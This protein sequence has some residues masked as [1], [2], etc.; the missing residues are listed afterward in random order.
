[1]LAATV[2][3]IVPTKE[4]APARFIVLSEVVVTAHANTV[5]ALASAQNTDPLLALSSAVEPINELLITPAE[6][7]AIVLPSLSIMPVEELSTVLAIAPAEEA[8]AALTMAHVDAAAPSL[9]V[10]HM[11]TAAT[12]LVI[13]IC[14]PG[15]CSRCHVQANE[16][17][18]TVGF[19]ALW[20]FYSSEGCSL[21]IHGAQFPNPASGQLLFSTNMTVSEHF[22]FFKELVRL[23]SNPTAVSFKELVRLVSNPGSG[24]GFRNLVVLVL[25]NQYV[26]KCFNSSCNIGTIHSYRSGQWFAGPYSG[27]SAEFSLADSDFDNLKLLPSQLFNA[28]NLAVPAAVT[29]H[30]EFF[31]S[32]LIF[33]PGLH[34]IVSVDFCS[35]MRQAAS[36]VDAQDHL[37]SVL[38]CMIRV[39]PTA[40]CSFV[41]SLL[42]PYWI[43]DKELCLTRHCELHDVD[44]PSSSVQEIKLFL[45][46]CAHCDMKL[47]QMD[48]TTAFISVA[49][50]HGELICCNPHCG[51]DI[52]L[53]SNGVPSVWK[54]QA[55]LESSCLAAMCW[56]ESSSIP[57]QSCG[58]VPIRSGSVFWMYHPLLEKMLLC[59]HV[60]DFPLAAFSLCLAQRFHAHY[61]LHCDCK[62][63]ITRTC[64]GIDIILDLDA[65]KMYLSQATLINCLLE[66]EL[67]GIMCHEHLTSTD[68][69]YN[70]GKDLHKWEQFCPCSTSFGYKMPKLLL[71]DS[72]DSQIP[73]PVLVHWK[74]VAVG[75]LMCTLNS[76]PDLTHPVHQVGCFVHNPGPAHAKAIDHFL[77]YLAGS[78]NFCL[79]VGN[80]TLFDLRFLAC[81]TVKADTSHKNLELDF[82]GITGIGIFV[83]C[84]LL[85]ARSLVQDQVAVSSAENEYYSSSS[86]VK[87]LDEPAIAMSQGPAHCSCTKHIDFTKALVRDYAQRERAGMEHCPTDEQFAD[88]WIKQLGLGSFVAYTG[89]FMSLV[90]FLRI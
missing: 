72:P 79:F 52:G 37:G 56:T 54:L 82:C 84:T 43:A 14:L 58:F 42:F 77:H 24:S 7:A 29:L 67:G 19:T 6:A 63:F 50:K 25:V 31:C 80:W 1:M 8:A 86:A 60:D 45:G 85:L 78:V 51:V 40:Y 13:V 12:A 49:L 16:S 35:L 22:M 88:M 4:A 62:F 70:P 71:V 73:D 5:L 20:G 2:Q 55:P 41:L 17:M 64:V 59:T 90:L 69:Q 27:G 38:S 47:F 36:C 11:E 3:A 9:A 66:Q 57:I 28:S 44:C 34:G 89:R 39:K 87:D 75:T 21:P 26:C 61:S 65:S 48:T 81:F 23:V 68:L 83:F 74:Q 76:H 30:A 53:V 33:Q 10:T 18:C 15:H 32:P 46:I